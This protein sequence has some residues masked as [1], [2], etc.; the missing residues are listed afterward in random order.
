MMGP[1]LFPDFHPHE[2]LIVVDENLAPDLTAQLEL[3][4]DPYPDLPVIPPDQLHDGD[5]LMMLGEGC[6]YIG[7]IPIPIS[8]I[9]RAL[10]GGAYSH[11]AVVSII[12]GQPNVW[13][14]SKDFVLGPVSLH[15]GI[16]EHKWCHVYRLDKNGEHAGSDRYPTAPIVKVLCA[17]KGDPYDM[18]L[19][20]MAGVVAVISR[21]PENPVVREVVRIALEALVFVLNWLL[22]HKDIRKGMLVCTAV[23][24]LSY[25]SALNK[26]PHDYALEV[27]I[28]R[29]RGGK[30]DAGWEQTIDRVKAVL[31]RVWP[32]FPDQLAQYEQTL[33]SNA[34]WVDVGGPLLPVNMVSPS[35]LEF[36]RTLQRVGRLKIPK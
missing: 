26:L 9:I 20:V 7:P 4:S 29:H 14:H 31:T 12:D 15:D 22:D 23:T 11:S 34:Q 36:S 16:K 2:E 19:L 25:W 17:H 5:V 28:Q 35:D 32:D 6:V 8:W 33:A 1:A 21:M 24:G 13:D 18:W 10:D 27:D 3:G 30:G